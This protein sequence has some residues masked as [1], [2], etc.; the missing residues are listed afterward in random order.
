MWFFTYQYT[1]TWGWYG[2]FGLDEQDPSVLFVEQACY[3]CPYIHNICGMGGNISMVCG[4]LPISIHQPEDGMVLLQFSPNLVPH[5]GYSDARM[6]RIPVHWLCHMLVGPSPCTHKTCGM[7]GNTSMAYYSS[8]H[9]P[10]DCLVCL[11]FSPNLVQELGCYV[12]WMNMVLLV[13]WLC[14]RRVIP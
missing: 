5:L 2:D 14:H 7:P 10:N 1:L 9:H 8:L 12:A 3:T 13:H 11:Q 6:N 4:S